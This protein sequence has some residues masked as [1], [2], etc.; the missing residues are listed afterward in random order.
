MPTTTA[1]SFSQYTTRGERKVATKLVRAALAAGYTISVNDGEDWTVKRATRAYDVLDALATT[2]EDTL[3]LHAADPSKTIGW[4]NAGS[5]YLVWGNADDGSELI[6][7][8]TANDLCEGLWKQAL[9]DM[10]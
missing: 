3:R 7:D 9:G 5:F 6:S 4:H 10:A 2:G 1:S 8:F